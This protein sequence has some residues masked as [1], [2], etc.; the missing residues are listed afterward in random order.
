MF[1]HKPHH[2]SLGFSGLDVSSATCDCAVHVRKQLM[3]DAFD[4]LRPVMPRVV[5]CLGWIGTMEVIA[6]R[7]EALGDDTWQGMLEMLQQHDIQL[8][9]AVR[10]SP[11]NVIQQLYAGICA[12][13]LLFNPPEPY[14]TEFRVALDGI[15]SSVP[16]CPP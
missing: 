1:E 15:G 9:P 14:G 8:A 2:G 13:L 3:A 10:A 5:G 12:E 4:L 6:V 7:T 16:I 11:G